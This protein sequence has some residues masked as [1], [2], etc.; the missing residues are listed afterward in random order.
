MVLT[1][2]SVLKSSTL[3]KSLV[4]P[5]THRQSRTES[6]RPQTRFLDVKIVQTYRD[7]TP[8]VKL[9]GPKFTTK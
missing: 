6:S 5:E 4:D 8:G 3:Y 9:I 7:Q 2:T 1:P